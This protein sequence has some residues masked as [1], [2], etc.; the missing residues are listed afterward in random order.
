MPGLSHNLTATKRVLQTNVAAGSG[1]CTTLAF[2]RAEFLTRG[3]PLSP[4]V[5]CSAA[6][7][8]EACSPPTSIPAQSLAV[9][10]ALTASVSTRR[11]ANQVDASRSAGP[12][13]RPA[14]GEPAR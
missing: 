9:R 8:E 5:A 14:T 6:T 12:A 11:V 7:G 13:A 10:V 4:C 2:P 1:Q 3:A